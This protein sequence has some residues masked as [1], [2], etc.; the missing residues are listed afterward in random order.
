MPNE[1][2]YEETRPNGRYYAEDHGADVAGVFFVGVRCRKAKYIAT[3]RVS[4]IESVKR[5]IE[6]HANPRPP[7]P[8]GVAVSIFKL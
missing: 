4:D 1:T 7:P 2:I 3:A 6:R 8:P 5:R